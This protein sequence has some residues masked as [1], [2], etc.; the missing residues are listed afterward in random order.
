M[1]SYRYEER[2]LEVYQVVL[3]GLCE[4]LNAALVCG[5]SRE[6]MVGKQLGW[7]LWRQMSDN[8]WWIV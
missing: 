8:I 5:S 6:E 7:H 3:D 2:D 4:K 1:V